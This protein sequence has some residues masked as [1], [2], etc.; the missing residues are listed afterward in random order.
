MWGGGGKA[1]GRGWQDMRRG[2]LRGELPPQRYHPTIQ[3]EGTAKAAVKC[4]A[5]AV[6]TIFI[7]VAIFHRALESRFRAKRERLRQRIS[8]VF[9]P[10]SLSSQ[11]T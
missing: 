11:L 8:E 2:E 5:L 1:G 4:G 10:F 9:C 7:F 3:R 6:A